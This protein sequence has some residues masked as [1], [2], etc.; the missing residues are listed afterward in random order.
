M[1]QI[2]ICSKCGAENDPDALKLK[3]PQDQQRSTKPLTKTPAYGLAGLAGVA[4]A[5]I[6]PT[7]R[8]WMLAIVSLAVSGASLYI[9]LSPIYKGER[10]RW[11]M[12]AIAAVMSFW[13]GKFS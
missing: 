7:V 3:E 8:L 10:V 12:T 11:A 1:K 4:V 9:L 5:P 2:W 6:D 13:F